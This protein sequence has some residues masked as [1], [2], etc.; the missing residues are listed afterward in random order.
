MTSTLLTQTD[1]E[2]ERRVRN[3]LSSRKLLKSENLAITAAAGTVT[4]GG[5]VRSY[6]ARQL[7][8]HGCLRVPGVIDEIAVEK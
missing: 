2:L 1:H 8:L 5:C 4:L 3:A 7:L 6:Y